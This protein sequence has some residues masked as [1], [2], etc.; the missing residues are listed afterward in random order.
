MSNARKTSVCP[1]MAFS[2]AS[3]PPSVPVAAADA[4]FDN[5]M[6]LNAICIKLPKLWMSCIQVWFAQ[7]QAQFA[8]KGVSAS[9]T[10]Y[11]Y[12]VQALLPRFD[13]LRCWTG[14]RPSFL[15]SRPTAPTSSSFT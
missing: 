8:N 11:F 15:K 12:I 2:P 1:G 4:L 6:L 5:A 3:S 14:C 7:A 10:R 9:L 13:H